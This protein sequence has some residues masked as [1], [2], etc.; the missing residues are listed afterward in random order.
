MTNKAKQVEDAIEK[1][2]NNPYW[3]DYIKWAYENKHILKFAI[4]Y[5]QASLGEGWQPIEVRPKYKQDVLVKWPSG[6]ERIAKYLNDEFMFKSDKGDYLVSKI[7]YTHWKPLEQPSEKMLK[8][9]ME[10]LG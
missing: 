3:A 8:E 10:D 2:P 7:G 9:F 5:L 1:L 6:A 4:K